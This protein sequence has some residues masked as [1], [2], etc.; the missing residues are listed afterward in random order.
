MEVVASIEQ[1]TPVVEERPL[2]FQEVY[3]KWL[4]NVSRWVRALG[5][6]DADLDDLTQ[7]VFIVVERRLASFD[8]TNLGGWLYQITAH[9]VR[10]YRRKVWFRNLF[11]RARSVELDAL[12]HGGESSAE[13][14]E[15][16]QMHGQLVMLLEELSEKHR[17][18]FVLYEIE[19]M[20]GEEIAA[21]ESVPLQTV[22]SR[23]HHARKK[24]AQRLAK[25]DTKE[26]R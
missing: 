16:K 4:L 3:K 25:L 15:R 14:Y 18:T 22:W 5:G 1:V 2:N 20:S 8:G 19:G 9:Q 7:E 10:D 23:L 11:R 17:A 6:L 13:A 26:N 24:L 21:L 12:A